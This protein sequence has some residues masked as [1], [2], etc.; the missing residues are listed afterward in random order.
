MCTIINMENFPQG[1]TAHTHLLLGKTFSQLCEQN[2]FQGKV[3]CQENMDNII[4]FFGRLIF[5]VIVDSPVG[6]W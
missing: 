6:S 3:N 5:K 4:N 1:I 2:S